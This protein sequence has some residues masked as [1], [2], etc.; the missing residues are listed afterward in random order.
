V[1]GPE[2][3]EKRPAR[4]MW[5][6]TRPPA[7][8]QLCGV[9]EETPQSLPSQHA[10]KVVG[11]RILRLRPRSIHG[12]SASGDVGKQSAARQE[13]STNVRGRREEGA[14]VPPSPLPLGEPGSGKSAAP[15]ASSVGFRP[16]QIHA[17]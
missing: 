10:L 7:G 13:G 3:A 9:G 12:R 14:A 1:S 5:N 11:R 6:S 8:W 16:F 2:L 15:S 17:L 4:A